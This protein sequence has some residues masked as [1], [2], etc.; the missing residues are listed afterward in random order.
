MTPE[1]DSAASPVQLDDMHPSDLTGA[2]EALDGVVCDFCGERVDSVRRVAL[3]G[4][5]ERLRTRH[6]AQYSCGDCF[7]KKER[8]R[9]GASAG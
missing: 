8:Q 4:A 9:Q 7:E 1:A 3:D 2:Q 6:Q 5:Y